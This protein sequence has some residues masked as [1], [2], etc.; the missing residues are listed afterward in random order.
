MFEPF[1]HHVIVD[2]F[3]FGN[4]IIRRYYLGDMRELRDMLDETYHWED[5]F[6]RI[7]ESDKSGHMYSR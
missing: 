6:Y 2:I 7:L 4:K 3:L 1:I 5:C